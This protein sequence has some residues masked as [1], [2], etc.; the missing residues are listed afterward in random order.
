MLETKNTPEEQSQD[1]PTKLKLELVSEV[2]TRRKGRDSWVNILFDDNRLVD[3]G[4]IGLKH[5][6][7]AESFRVLAQSAVDAGEAKTRLQVTELH[8]II[9]TYPIT[10]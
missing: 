8:E 3:F 6:R 1:V 4:F 2:F 10:R 5:E 7:E 9:A